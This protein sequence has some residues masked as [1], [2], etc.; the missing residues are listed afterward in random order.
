MPDG[1]GVRDYIH[2]GDLAKGYVKALQDLRDDQQVL[3]VNLDAGDGYLVLHMVKPFEKVS[4]KDVP[5]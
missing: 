5:Y 3:T 1:A 2:V 4:G